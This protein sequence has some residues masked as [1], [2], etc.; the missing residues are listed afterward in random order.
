MHVGRHGKAL[1]GS[2]YGRDKQRWPGQFA[3]LGVR[4]G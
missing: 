3:K 2:L 1:A 4:F